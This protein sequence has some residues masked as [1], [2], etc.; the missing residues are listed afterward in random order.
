MKPDD[1]QQQPQRKPDP[2]EQMPGGNPQGGNPPTTEADRAKEKKREQQ[3][4]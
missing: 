3:D 1:P 4:D 2:I